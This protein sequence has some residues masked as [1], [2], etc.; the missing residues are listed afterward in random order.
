MTREMWRFASLERLA[1]EARFALR[2]PRR[3]PAFTVTAVLIL[4]LGIGMASAMFT[5]YQ[6]ILLKKPPVQDQDRVV[7]LSGFGRGAATEVE[8]VPD[9]YRRFRAQTRTL[10]SAASFAH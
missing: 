6:S 8:L 9:V 10:Q 2:S 4:A 1:R 3:T 5:A 7:E